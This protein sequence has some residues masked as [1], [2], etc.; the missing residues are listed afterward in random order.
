MKEKGSFYEDC[1]C[2]ALPII[3]LETLNCIFQAGNVGIY[4]Y[5]LP[6]VSQNK[7]II[8]DQMCHKR[9]Q[10]AREEFDANNCD[11]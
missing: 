9:K 6:K 1:P 4:C 8:L 10:I 2:S 5:N 7:V 11:H 3:Q